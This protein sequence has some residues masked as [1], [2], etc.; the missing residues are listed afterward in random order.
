M[1]D[2]PQNFPKL[3][4]VL[5]VVSIGLTE[6]ELISFVDRALAHHADLKFEIFRSFED[7]DFSWKE[8]LNHPD[9]GEVID[10]ETEEEAR[11]F[12]S[13]MFLRPAM[14]YSGST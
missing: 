10:T 6:K 9:I 3:T 7:P 5:N 2:Y 14:S 1:I 12:A 8:I 11:Q 13:E 4:H